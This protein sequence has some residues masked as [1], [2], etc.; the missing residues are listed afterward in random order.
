VRELLDEVLNSGIISYGYKS[1]TFEREFARI[2]QA[3]YGTLSNSGTSSLQVALQ[4]LKE[5]YNWNRGDEV[6]VP[7]TTF[8]A[9]SNI[10]KHNDMTPVFVDIEPIYYG[11]DID[12][13]ESKITDRTRAII[14]VHLF[15]QPCNISAIIEI[16]EV[17]DLKVIVDS[18]ET[19][20]VAHKGR[21]VGSWGDIECFS[22]YSA[23]LL[24]AGVG[25]IATTS[26]SDYSAKMRSLVNHGLTLEN[27]NLDE[28][29]SPKPMVGRKFLFDAIGHSFRIT[30]FEAAVALAQLEVH[31][32]MIGRRNQH[33]RHYTASL[34]LHNSLFDQDVF[35]PVRIMEGNEHAFMMYPIVLKNSAMGHKEKLTQFLNQHGIETRDMLPILNQPAY[36][37]LPKQDFPVS[38]NIV[39][40]GFYVGCHQ[41]L[42]SDQVQFVLDR[43]YEYAI[44]EF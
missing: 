28:Y 7:A 13:I 24:T 22:M 15:G 25:G 42:T 10:V 44:K 12:Q 26:N 36:V 41:Y 11:I 40:N 43:L 16:A 8:V 17:Y 5:L 19:M 20:F 39:L 14:P 33:G 31:K 32:E 34:Q 6:L 4:T 23:H 35:Q 21:M 37:Y 29:M 18:C 38:W 27:L 9:T 3:K 30:E 2:H 1:R